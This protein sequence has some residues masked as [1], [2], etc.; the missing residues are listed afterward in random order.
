MLPIVYASVGNPL[1]F[2][3]ISMKAD[4]PSEIDV[5]SVLQRQ[6]REHYSLFGTEP[7]KIE[8]SR[9][10]DCYQIRPNGIVGRIYC[11]Q[12]VL[13]ISSK[14][15]NIEIGKWL[16]LAHYSGA[17]H[18]VQHNNDVAE[19]AVSERDK[20]DGIDYFIVALISSIYDCVNN[21][22]IYEKGVRD[23]DDPNF[24]GK[25]NVRK[26]IQRGANPF[27]LQTTQ[28][29]RLFDCNANSILKRALQV[30]S[31][32]AV[33]INL[34]G[35]T[36]EILG[37]FSE[38]STKKVEAGPITYEFVSSLPRP[39]YERALAIS[40]IILEGFSAVQG[41]E[42]SF[43]PYYTINLD[44][45]FEKYVGFELQKLLREDSYKVMLQ[46]RLSHPIQPGLEGNFIAPDIVVRAASDIEARPVVVDTKNKYSMLD[47]SGAIRISNQDLFQMVYYCQTVGSN[48]AILVY[49]GGADTSTKYPL[50]G[51]EG[52]AQYLRKRSAAVTSMFEGGNCAFE[53]KTESAQIYIIAWRIN[54]SGT[55]HESREAMAQLSQFIADCVRREIL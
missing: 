33:N 4:I 19:S 8:Y 10:K 22:L 47:D 23:G 30:C 53:Y 48:I 54:L 34:R 14:F 43:V 15:E 18:L 32:K 12:F 36:N 1:T 50:F 20:F 29:I 41:N 27:K 13:V 35:L 37:Q 2:S 46:Q 25:L 39:E 24:R 11:G 38:V 51:S 42:G 6:I 52:R 21:G 26:Y 7:Y 16:Q 17:N 45:L 9:E 3:E 49:P 55:L 31:A 5:R 40:K 28:N 44:E